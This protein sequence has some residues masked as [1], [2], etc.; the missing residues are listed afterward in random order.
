MIV[1]GRNTKLIK[2]GSLGK[3]IVALHYL[4]DANRNRNCLPLLFLIVHFKLAI[5]GFIEAVC[6]KS[7]IM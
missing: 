2:I 1:P 4:F 7:S 5:K 3:I 6:A